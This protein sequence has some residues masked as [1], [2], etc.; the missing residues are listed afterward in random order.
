MIFGLVIAGVVIVLIVVVVLGFRPRPKPLPPFPASGTTPET[1]PLPEGLPAPVE[2]FYRQVYG[3]RIP[4]ITTAV[5][6]GRARLRLSGIPLPGRF[7]F[8]HI[9]GEGY[10]HYIEVTFFGRPVVR[11]HEY[12]IDGQGRLELPVGVVADEPKVDQGANLGLWSETGWMPAVYLTDPRVCWE[13]VDGHTAVLVVPFGEHEER[14]IVRFDPQTGMIRFFEAMRYK[15]ADSDGKTLW[16]DEA[17]EWGPVDRHMTL[18]RASVTWFDE[19]IPW[20]IFFTDELVFNA[21]VDDYIRS[22]QV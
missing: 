10:R 8:T 3:S 5:I 2:R 14:F 18:T 6:S 20:A 17:L 22:H 9:A 13:A 1:I 15:D 12:Y 21:D 16:I 7:R 4:V 19:G 11:V